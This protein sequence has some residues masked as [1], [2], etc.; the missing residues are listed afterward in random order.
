MKGSPFGFVLMILISASLVSCEKEYSNESGNIPTN[1]RGDL[2]VGIVLKDD[3]SESRITYQYNTANQVLNNLYQFTSSVVNG[4]INTEAT[5]D[6]AG[7]ITKSRLVVKTNLNPL[8]DTLFYE[9]ARNASGKIV[10]A[11]VKGS[12]SFALVAYDSLVYSY[13]SNKLSGVINYLVDNITGAVEPYQ[14]FEYIY[15]GAN[16]TKAIEYEL[17]G[18]AISPRLVETITLEYDTKPAALALG[19]DEYIVGLIPANLLFPCINNV[20]KYESKNEDDPSLNS[21]NTY[22]YIYGTSAKPS[23][24]EIVTS[25]VGL[26]DSKG[27]M[28]FTYQ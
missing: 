12:E 23:S 6:A 9:L 25:R 11:V 17:S 26:P 15:T 19:E 2:L 10:H 7:L 27:T 8:G 18:S 20:T 14:K 16:V 21:I 3:F 4:D 28:V 13:S 1:P 22:T 24:A 5:R